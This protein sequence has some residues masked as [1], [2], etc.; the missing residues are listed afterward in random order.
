MRRLKDWVRVCLFRDAPLCALHQK[1]RQY[2]QL[3]KKN[4]PFMKYDVGYFYQGWERL[5]IS[6][7][8]RTE[9]RFSQY[10]VEEILRELRKQRAQIEVLDVGANVGFFALN[11]AP[12]VTHIDAVEV[13]PYLVKIGEEAAR[14]LGISNVKYHKTDF[15]QFHSDKQYDLIIALACY[16]TDDSKINI[17]LREYFERLYHLLKSGG[18]LLFES[19][20]KDVNNPHFFQ[21]ID[22]LND[23]F[24]KRKEKFFKNSIL[25]GGKRYFY[26][27]EKK[28]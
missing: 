21:V 18:V 7:I 11:L 17:E 22:S 4:W 24:I 16:S 13:N 15:T 3:Q 5:K 19:H 10:E 28:D 25:R 2:L 1:F 6:G 12:Y 26:V 8:R 14:Y 20:N 27:F 23:L 9:E